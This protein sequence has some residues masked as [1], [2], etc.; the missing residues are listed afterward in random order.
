MN[1]LITGG[2]GFIGSNL[3]R[4]VVDRPEIAHLINLDCLTYAG[5]RANVAGVETHPKYAFDPTDLRD[6]EAVRRAVSRHDVTHVIH[7]AAETHVDRSIVA[8]DAFVQ[9]NVL[10]TLHLL[11]ACREHWSHSSF[12]IRHSSLAPRF[13]HVSTDEVYGSL[14]PN[15]AAFTEA[16]PLQPNSPYAASK[17]GGDHLVR[18]YIQTY[19][20]PAIVTRCS[21]NYGPRQHA[22]KLIPTVLNCLRTRRPIPLYGDGLNVRDW[23]HVDDHGEA[24][25]AVL[26]NGREGETY[27]I[28]GR[29]ERSNLDAVQLLCDLV[30]ELHPE[31]GG[32]SRSLISFVKDRPGHDRRYA[33]DASKLEIELHWQPVRG[34]QAGLRETVRWYLDFTD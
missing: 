30:D 32:D 26:A 17:A 24:L 16:S 13:V 33:I 34:F 25:W 10:G 12:A 21:N 27:N 15:D 29:N 2:A 31:L 3:I 20:F 28:G 11:D 23:L 5:N 14:G 22:E 6:R 8:P 18:S 9:T 19:G 7:L 1:L 4:Q